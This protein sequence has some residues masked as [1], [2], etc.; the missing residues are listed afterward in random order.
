MYQDIDRYW[1]TL[2]DTMRTMTTDPIARIAGELHACYERGGTVFV[3]GNGGS[4]ATASHFACD[5]AKGTRAGG[6]PTFRVLSLTDN[7]PMLTAWAND[8][9]YDCALAEQ[10]ASFIRPEDLVVAISASGNSPNVLNAVEK[11]R[12]AGAV[13]VGLTGKGGGRLTNLVH[14]AL[15]VPSDSIEQVEDV[16]VI[17]THSVCVA[18]RNRIHAQRTNG[19]LHM[20]VPAVELVSGQ[21]I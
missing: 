19:A 13:T 9:D 10:L 11:A 6:G 12:E 21:V 17:V 5:L 20:P 1:H 4:A 7:V 18:L 15:R 3:L 16:H 2:I 14:L 8:V